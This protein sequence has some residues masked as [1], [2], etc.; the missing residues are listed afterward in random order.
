MLKNQLHK[1]S[2]S[3]KAFIVFLDDCEK[4][5]PDRTT[6]RLDHKKDVV[7]EFLHF[8][9][10][11]NGYKNRGNYLLIAT[12]NLPQ[13]ID[14]ALLSRFGDGVF[15]CE[16]PLT[17][18][19]KA[20]V[21]KQNL[22]KGIEQG[23]VSVSNWEDIGS[24]AMKYNLKGRDLYNI[25]RTLLGESRS[26]MDYFEAYKNSNNP[27]VV[28]DIILRSHT[29]ID[30]EMIVRSIEHFARNNNVVDLAQKSYLTKIRNYDNKPLVVNG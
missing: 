5:F 2:S 14:K 20:N 16:G 25:A 8:T 27:E 23:F 15:H 12:A 19:E 22:S 11:L 18:Y 17:S 21:L 29:K 24:L 7:T 30:D 26:S 4:Y 10:G 28:R 9:Q 1:I 6:S 13:T 3:N